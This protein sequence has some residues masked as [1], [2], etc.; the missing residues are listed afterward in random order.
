M[1]FKDLLI[2]H[3]EFE[4]SLYFGDSSTCGSER[5][6]KWRE[7]IAI[8]LDRIFKSEDFLDFY[9]KDDEEICVSI[10]KGQ[11]ELEYDIPWKK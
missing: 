8:S 7:K 2:N 4:S 1:I 9:L 3:P 5:L 11:I 6:D 10:K